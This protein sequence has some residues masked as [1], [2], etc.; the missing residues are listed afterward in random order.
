M[1]AAELNMIG[2]FRQYSLTDAEDKPKIWTPSWKGVTITVLLGVNIILIRIIEALVYNRISAPTLS[3]C[4]CFTIKK[5]LCLPGTDMSGGCSLCPPDWLL[6]GDHC[7]YYSDVTERTWNQS[8]DHC[9]MMGANLLVIKDQEQQDFI[10]RTIRQRVDDTYWI[11]LQRDGDDWRWVDGEHYNSSLL[12]IKTQS[13][14]C[15]SM[16]RSGYYPSSCNSTY[17]WIC[18]KKAVKI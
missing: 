18:L 16:N 8:R 4:E 1:E 9:K 12:Q 15:V 11:G 14:R 7:Y 2:Y 10:L 6:H 13:G 17:R 5:E 3:E